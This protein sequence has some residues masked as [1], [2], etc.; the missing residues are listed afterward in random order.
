MPKYGALILAAGKGTRMHSDKPKVLQTLLGEPMLRF[1]ADALRPLFR[2][3]VWTVIGHRADM[4]R[5]AFGDEGLHFVVQEEQLGTGHAL[6]QALPALEDAGCTHVLVVNGDTPLLG[7]RLPEMFLR[8][9]EQADLSFATITLQDPAAYG[10]V[11][12]HHGRVVAVVEAKDYDEDLYGPEPKE[13]NAGLYCLNLA[14]VRQLLPH[15]TNANKS[16]E[17]Y[18]TD[19]IGLAVENQYT[20]RGVECGDD[21]NLFGVNSPVELSRSEALLG[22]QQVQNLLQS[23]VILHAAELIR[24]SP[25]ARIE[26]GAELYGPCEIYGCSRVARGACIESH[27]VLRDAVVA[28]GAVIRS[29]SHLEKAE[30]GPGALVGPYARLRPGAVLEAR[31]HVGNFVELKKARLGQGAKANHLSYIGDAEVGEG[32]NIGAGA[33]TC[34]YD[35]TNKHKTVIGPRAF[36]GSNTALVAPVSVGEQAL[37]GAGSVITKNVPD[38]TL[39]VARGRQTN[40]PRKS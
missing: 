36:I 27:C 1:V 14:M 21:P 33:I 13:V 20:V 4:V 9:S 32:T 6:M 18:I 11:V 8:E 26:P 39:A 31:A 37:V 17:Y 5:A 7:A 3:A 30:V 25:R 23:G 12:R 10:R 24:V 40:L 16:G 28:E 19:L 34:N 38:N 29:F 15:L 22:L 35:G 2:D